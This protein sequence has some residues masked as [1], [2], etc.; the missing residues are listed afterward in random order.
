[1]IPFDNSYARLPGTMHAGA[2]PTPV[3][4]PRLIKVNAPLARELGID[5][6][7]L[8]AEMAVGNVLP[9]GAA[10]IAQ[11]YAGHQFGTLVPQLGDGRAI[12]LGEVVDV[13]GKRRDIQLKG[14]GQTPF[15]RRGDGRAALGP[16]LR[17]YLVS[18]A[19]H[20]L[21]IPSTRALMA[22]TT[23]EK[24]YRD[25]VLP[26]AVLTR[27][28]ASHIRVGTFQFFAVRR[29]L[30]SL[31]ALIEHVIARHYPALQGVDNPALAL[32]DAVMDA[33]ARLVSRWVGIG[34]IHGVMNTD[35]MS[36][37]G[38]TIDYG[39]CAFMDAYD[40]ATVF[41]SIDTHGRYAYENQAPI[42]QWNL[43]RLAESL[44]PFIDES[45]D[46]AIRIATGRIEAFPAI[47]TRHWLDVFRRK[48]GLASEEDGDM[49]LI[50]ALLDALQL[51]RA[52]FTIS[53]RSLANGED[54]AVLSDWLPK[55]RERLARDP[56][57]DDQRR[58]LMRRA[59]P[60]YI[61]RNHRVE[62]MI[63]AAV[64]REDYAPFEDML[65]VLMM[66]YDEQPGA[67]RYA[68]APGETEKVYRTFCGT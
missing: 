41:S 33:Q 6:A 22:A 9:E 46:D 67:Q 54:P 25:T 30:D 29:D 49:D 61:P 2:Q 3:T 27:V 39:P 44:L 47:Y 53:F 68:E 8:T 38:E 11:A 31:K 37:S 16:V 45:R 4:A 58:T 17:E 59:N 64:E 20:A 5:P 57:D 52:D 19:M 18:E 12:L 10:P 40:P 34:F 65:R 35:N 24:V 60:A 66:P 1:M 55:W 32:L 15:S 42:A 26:G 62:D 28:A 21:G 36:I 50:Q 7:H 56:Q 23:G 13:N 43:A 14:A 63:Q 51:A 48:I